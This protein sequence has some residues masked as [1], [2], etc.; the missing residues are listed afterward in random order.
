MTVPADTEPVSSDVAKPR[1]AARLAA[2]QAIFQWRAT[3]NPVERVLREFLTHRLPSPEGRDSYD[4]ADT[5]FFS[6]LVRG[7]ATDHEDLDR[8]ISA[9]LA[10]EAAP[11]STR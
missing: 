8:E 9:V 11:V 5:E 4:G 1:R 7:V 10:T 6:D 3:E 2:V